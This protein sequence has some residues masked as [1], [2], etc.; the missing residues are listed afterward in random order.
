MNI[1]SKWF[2]KSLEED[3][4]IQFYK[5]KEDFISKLDDRQQEYHLKNRGIS[6]TEIILSLEKRIHLLEGKND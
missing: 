2:K 3:S 4:T 6:F 1:F 5:R